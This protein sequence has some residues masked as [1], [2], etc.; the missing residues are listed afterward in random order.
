MMPWIE[1]LRGRQDRADEGGAAGIQKHFISRLSNPNRPDR[2]Q[3]DCASNQQFNDAKGRLVFTPH[4]GD[5]HL[6]HILIEGWVEP[7]GADIGAARLRLIGF[8]SPR[9]LL[10]IIALMIVRTGQRCPSVIRDRHSGI[11]TGLM[12]PFRQVGGEL[13]LGDRRG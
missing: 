5:R 2:V 11:R 3:E 9:L 12:R 4:N 13:S 6:E 7:K 1:V 10:M 8:L